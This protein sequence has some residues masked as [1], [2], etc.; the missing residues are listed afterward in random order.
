M[1]TFEE[2]KMFIDKN[3]RP[4]SLV[5][6]LL[7]DALNCVIAEDVMSPIA[8]PHLGTGYGSRVL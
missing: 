4:L 7:K 8:S 6:V 2:A 5:K 3:T 1:V